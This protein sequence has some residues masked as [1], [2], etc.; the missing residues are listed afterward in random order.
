MHCIGS[1]G[2]NDKKVRSKGK[3]NQQIEANKLKIPLQNC[4]TYPPNKCYQIAYSISC[5]D[6]LKN[7]I[8]QPKCSRATHFSKKEICLAKIA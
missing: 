3:I 1:S 7:G 5:Q 8:M 6:Q 2:E 4:K